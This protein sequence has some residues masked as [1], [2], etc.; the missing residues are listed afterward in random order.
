MHIDI[1]SIFL[2]LVSIIYHFKRHFVNDNKRKKKTKCF[3]KTME[4]LASDHK[5]EPDIFV[6]RYLTSCLIR[7]QGSLK[8]NTCVRYQNEH[9]CDP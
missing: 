8:K 6:S 2:H 3:I 1:Q 5:E 4:M 7:S 9:E